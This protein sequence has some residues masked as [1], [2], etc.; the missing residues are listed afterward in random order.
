VI[1]IDKLDEEMKEDNYF[2]FNAL[3]DNRNRIE[4]KVAAADIFQAY[5][6]LRDDY[7]YTIL[8]LYPMSLTD[9]KEQD[10][11]FQNV[12]SVFSG[13]SNQQTP[14]QK[15]ITQI[16]TNTI[17]TGEISSLKKNFEIITPLVQESNLENKEVILYDMKKILMTNSLSAMQGILKKTTKLLY[18]KSDTDT[19]RKI[20]K[21]ILPIIKRNGIFILPPWYFIIAESIQKTSEMF[22]I[23]FL[24]SE[25]T[26]KIQQQKEKTKKLAILQILQKK[27][28][29]EKNIYSNK[30]IQILLQ[31]K[32]R[33]SWLDL[34]KI[35]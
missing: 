35:E 11:I 19:K 7:Q 14:Q 29:Q 33:S 16:K 18:E 26:K 15:N 28:P 34:F 8:K 25:I 5:K 12:V 23:L 10:F 1:T 2:I 17:T 3:K 22:K 13:Y 31:K 20:Y 30:N 9:K 21:T 27:N 4:G 32:Y 6:I 24:P